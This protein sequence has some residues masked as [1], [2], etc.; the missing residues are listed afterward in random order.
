MVC[1]ALGGNDWKLSCSAD[2]GNFRNYSRVEELEKD[3]G[4]SYIKELRFDHRSAK[5][6]ETSSAESVLSITPAAREQGPRDQCK[7]PEG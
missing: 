5:E 6:P 3:E 1:G 4:Q 2:F 7:N